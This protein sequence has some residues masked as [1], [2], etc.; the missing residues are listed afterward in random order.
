MTAAWV[1]FYV[2]NIAWLVQQAMLLHIAIKTQDLFYP[3]EE[4]RWVY[5]NATQQEAQ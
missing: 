5:F 3:K 4:V 1:S 2:H